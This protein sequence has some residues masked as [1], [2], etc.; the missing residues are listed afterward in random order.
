MFS[1]DKPYRD[2]GEFLSARFPFKVQ[3]ISINAGFTCPNRDGSKGR[4]GC[5]YCNN[6]SFSPGYGKPDKSVTEQM[7]DGIDFFSHKY[8]E[9]KYLAYFQSYTNTYESKDSLIRKYEE[10]LAT[11]NVVGLIVGTRPD[12]MS[13]WL[14]DYFEDLRKRIF[15][16]LEYGVESTLNKTLERVNRQHTYEESAVMIRKT[17]ERMIP[18]GAHMI[19]GLPGETEEDILHHAEELSKLPL[20]TLKLHQLQIIKGTA[21]AK[22]FRLLPESFNLFSL[23]E[24]IDMCVDFAERLNPEI[25]IERFT[26]QSP[27][28]LLIAPDWGLK[29][30]EVREKIIKRFLERETWQGRLFNWL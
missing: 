26:S 9:M 19:L 17:A 4:G 2:F 20:T 12:C 11:P 29:N 6:Q 28:K 27:A 21:M 8:P 3:K 30:Y 10:A 1:N 14:L 24:Y 18:T 16:M 13:D 7:A 25:Y 15:V 23:E 5:T 22:E